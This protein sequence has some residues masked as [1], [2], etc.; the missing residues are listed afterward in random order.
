[1]QKFVSILIYDDFILKGKKYKLKSRA[2]ELS[3]E[4]VKESIQAQ[5]RY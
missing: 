4:L 1:V 3:N 2:I 5:K